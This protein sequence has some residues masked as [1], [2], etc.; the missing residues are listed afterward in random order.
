MTLIIAGLFLAAPLLAEE[1][2]ET[3][4]AAPDGEV[5]ISN[6]AGSITVAGWSRNAVEVTGTLGRNVEKLVFERDGDNILI[7]VKVPRKGGRG[8]DA[9]LNIR[10]PENSSIDVSGVSADISVEGVRGEQRLQ[11][12]SGDVETE[13]FSNDVSAESVSGDVEVEGD[14]SDTE[15]SISTVSGD[16]TLEEGSGT[17]RAG[18]VSGDVIIDQGSFERAELGTVNGDVVFRSGL[19][20]GGRFSAET[21]NGSLDIEFAGDFS[22]R[23]EIETFN[24]S[25]R[26]C[27]GPEPERTSKYTPGLELSFTEGDGDGRVE[28]STMNGDISICKD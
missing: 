11:T 24:G 18:S 19:R 6:I 10:V 2:D 20:K 5:D 21:V 9:D 28:M 7:Q 22:A 15:T 1:V 27:F 16:V 23:V 17:V 4:E 26:N 25:I 12:V 14:A 8:T 13:S 3:L